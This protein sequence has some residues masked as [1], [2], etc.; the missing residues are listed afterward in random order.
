MTELDYCPFCGEE[1][2]LTLT[3]QGSCVYVSCGH[4]AARGQSYAMDVPYMAMYAGPVDR[5]TED[6]LAKQAVDSWNDPGLRH[7]PLGGRIKNKWRN[8]VYDVE[9][10]VSNHIDNITDW[11]DSRND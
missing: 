4:C 10:W 11:G 6:Q 1:N 2:E 3:T 8:A 7:Q 9:Q 5:V